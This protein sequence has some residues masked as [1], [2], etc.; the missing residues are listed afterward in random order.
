MGPPVTTKKQNVKHSC[1]GCGKH[2][3]VVGPRV[4]LQRQPSIDPITKLAELISVHNNIVA[5][6]GAGISVSCGIPDFRSP[7]SGLYA[8]IEK[9]PEFESL[10]EPQCLFDLEQFQADPKFF[11]S[12]ARSLYQQRSLTPSKAH[13]F[14][15][16]LEKRQKLR[17]VYSQNIDGLELAAGVSREKLVQCHGTMES[18]TCQVKSCKRHV[19]SE[20]VRALLASGEILVCGEIGCQKDDS[21][22]A[23]KMNLTDSRK[24]K[25]NV[26]EL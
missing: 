25:R 6:V 14:L 10:S 1:Y 7:E 8:L 4:P 17:R 16:E 11:F 12:F 22:V 21:K 9:M 2:P 5:I 13:F 23:N 19:E 18:V 3:V 24:R 15:A 26:G 20:M